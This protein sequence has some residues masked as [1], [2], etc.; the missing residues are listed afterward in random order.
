MT[1]VEKCV[2]VQVVKV[3]VQNVKPSQ[4]QLDRYHLQ[5]HLKK[6]LSLAKNL[7]D[8]VTGRARARLGR[9]VRAQGPVARPAAREGLGVLA[10]A[11]AFG[12][13]NGRRSLRI[14]AEHGICRSAW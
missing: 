5:F 12:P 6:N 10:S 8:E 3:R 11:A 14:Y 2:V 9:L 13:G 7:K 4:I 1:P